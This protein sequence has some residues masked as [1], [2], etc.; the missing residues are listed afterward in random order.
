MVERCNAW[1]LVLFREYNNFIEVSSPKFHQDRQGVR[2][3][4]FCSLKWLSILNVHN[5]GSAFGLPTQ[6]VMSSFCLNSSSRV[7]IVALNLHTYK[8]SRN[9]FTAGFRNMSN[10]RSLYDR[11]NR[12]GNSVKTRNR[13]SNGYRATMSISQSIKY[14]FIV[15]PQVYQRAGQLCLR[16]I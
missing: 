14:Y 16:H 10:N 5:T 1:T 9:S 12:D 8:M 6:T 11:L 2:R 3:P 15:R 7:V 13:M 4:L